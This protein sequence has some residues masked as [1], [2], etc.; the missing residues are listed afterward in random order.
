VTPARSSSTVTREHRG[1]GLAQQVAGLGRR[2]ALAQQQPV[3]P[4]GTARA[5]Q[6]EAPAQLLALEHEIEL[7]RF[8]ARF[9]RD[10]VDAAIHA[11]VPH[12]HRAGAV[13]AGGDHA[14]EVGV[15]EGMVLGPHREALLLRI[16]GGALRHR[17]AREGAGDL[18]AQVVVEPPR[19]VLLHHEAAGS[20]RPR[21]R[22]R[23]LPAERLRCASGIALA[24]VG[25]EIS[26]GAADPW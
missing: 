22:G 3:A 20:A 11:D 10:A 26:H 5:H 12:D 9:G 13:V 8:E 15:L 14:L 24:A 4:A 17:P 18:E 2:R 16:Q 7:P 6:R 19:R 25:L 21:G 23:V 1:R